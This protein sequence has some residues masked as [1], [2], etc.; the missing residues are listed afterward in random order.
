V[1]A[2]AG[3][4]ATPRLGDP[5]TLPAPE[6]DVVVFH[7]GTTRDAQGRLVTAGGRVLTVSAVAPTV[8]AAQQRSLAH[9]RRVEFAGRQLRT[10]IGWREI[11]RRSERAGAGASRD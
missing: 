2:A 6:D 8:E 1:L 11:A 7:A 3:Y 10:D 9:A 5:I 4:P